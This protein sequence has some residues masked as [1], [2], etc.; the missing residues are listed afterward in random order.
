MIT[1]IRL[2][3]AASSGRNWKLTNGQANATNENEDEDER[4]GKEMSTIYGRSA[5]RCV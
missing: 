5:N 1:H 3:V 4:V 2:H